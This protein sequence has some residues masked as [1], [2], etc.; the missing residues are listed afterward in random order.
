M[1]THTATHQEI[2]YYHSL[3]ENW[4]AKKLGCARDEREYDQI[5]DDVNALRDKTNA[6]LAEAGKA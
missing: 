2:M 3:N 5:M 6:A 1:Q 4:L